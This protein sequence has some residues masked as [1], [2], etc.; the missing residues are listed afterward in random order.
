MVKSRFAFSGAMEFAMCLT[1]ARKFIALVITWKC[2]A[3][4]TVID[5]KEMC[6]HIASITRLWQALCPIVWLIHFRWK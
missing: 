5:M 3:I 6:T 4:C 2:S 1:G